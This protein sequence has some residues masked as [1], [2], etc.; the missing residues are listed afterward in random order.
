MRCAHLRVG[1]PYGCRLLFLDQV[2]D[3]VVPVVG[4]QG[5][6]GG[7]HVAPQLLHLLALLQQL[8]AAQ[9]RFPGDEGFVVVAGREETCKQCKKRKDQTKRG[10]LL[11]V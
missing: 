3:L 9:V 11:F 1:H 10:R 5:E 6:G 8:L 7:E 2:R 4:V